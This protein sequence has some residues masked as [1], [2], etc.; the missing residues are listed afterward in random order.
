MK[1]LQKSRLARDAQGVGRLAAH[2]RS[3]QHCHSTGHGLSLLA[4]ISQVAGP[5]VL[6]GTRGSGGGGTRAPADSAPFKKASLVPS[7]LKFRG[8]DTPDTYY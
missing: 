3:L 5:P 4:T 1:Q 2:G 8:Y 7:P 6:T